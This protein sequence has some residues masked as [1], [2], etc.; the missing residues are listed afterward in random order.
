V[1]RVARADAPDVDVVIVAHDAGA[2]LKAALDSVAGQA[3]DGRIVVVDAESADGSV[4]ALAATHPDVRVVPAP[5]RGFSASNNVGIAATSGAYVLLLNPD[6]ELGVGSLEALVA[7]AEADPRS[8]IV[9]PRVLDAD[10]GVQRG[11]F[12]SFPTLAGTLALHVGRA[13]DRASG[14]RGVARSER[15]A[16]GSPD[17]VTGACMLVRR[18]AIADAGPMDEG[19]F[20]YFEDVEWCHRM[21]DHGWTVVIEPAASCVHHLGKS[22]AGPAAA[23]DAYRASFYRYCGLYHLWG[24]SAVA[25]L[26]IALRTLTGRRG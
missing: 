23:S 20:L 19:F 1:S 16:D 2:Y 11:S 10:G 9:A 18:A 14:G 6:A 24:L 3:G 15:A 17:W 4:D 13:L 22:G 8:A 25:R 21:R 26:G 12:G 5:N 7:Q